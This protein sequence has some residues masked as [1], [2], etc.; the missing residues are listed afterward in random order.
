MDKMLE[1]EMLASL[2][3]S[4]RRKL[5]RTLE[6]L[7]QDGTPT[8]GSSWKWDAILVFIVVS[9][10]LLAVWIG[11]LGVT[12]PR[13]YHTGSWRVAWVAFELGLLAS[14]AAAG[15]MALRRRQL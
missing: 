10:S 5:L 13:L 9:C 6:A 2:S 12:L 11:V 3:V 4:E 8:P 14:F 1:P 15:W 7:G